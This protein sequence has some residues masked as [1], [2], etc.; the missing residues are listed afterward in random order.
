MGWTQPI[1]ESFSVYNC[2][3][4]HRNKRLCNSVY[5]GQ[6]RHRRQVHPR[7]S[8]ILEVGQPPTAALDGP[9]R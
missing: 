4:D 6:V 3:R 8:P 2:S 1:N 9:T 7:H 5:I